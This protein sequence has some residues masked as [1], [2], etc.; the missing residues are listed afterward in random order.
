MPECQSLAKMT[1]MT[2]LSEKIFYSSIYSKF[3]IECDR[4]SK[5]PTNFGRFGFVLTA[6]EA[7]FRK[8]FFFSF[9]KVVTAGKSAVECISDD[10]IS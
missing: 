1:K 7:F 6:S 2:V 8:P 3:A 5:I 4:N 9:F 10:N